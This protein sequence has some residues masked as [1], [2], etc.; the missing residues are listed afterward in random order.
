MSITFWGQYLGYWSFVC[1]LLLIILYF[2]E[3]YCY[4]FVILFFLLFFLLLLF[5]FSV[6]YHYLFAFQTEHESKEGVKYEG[7]LEGSGK[8][9]TMMRIY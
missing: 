9:D 3:F 7:V 2:Y 1:I 5:L 8:V 6:F 4:L